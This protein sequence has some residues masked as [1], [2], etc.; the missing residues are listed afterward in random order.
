M[1]IIVTG[2]AGFIGS[3]ITDALL[4]AGH[5]V[6]IIDNLS[7]GRR[8][9][10]NPGAKFY[11]ADIRDKAVS[12]IFA[13]EKP[14]VVCHQAAQV[15]VRYSVAD[16]CADAD[17]N[18][19]GSI[20]L[21]ENCR[22]HGVGRMTFASS[23]GAIYGE[24]DVFPAPESHAFHPCSPYG[25]AKLSVEFYMDYYRQVFGLSYA[26]LRYSNVYGPRQ[27]P[28]G[29]AGVVAIFV[30]LMLEG[31]TPTVNGDGG[32]TRDYVYVKD[33]VAANV[34][35]IEGNAVGGFNI[36][37][38]IETSVNGLY[39]V[40]KEKTGY[41]GGNVHAPAK[42]GEQYRSV[43]DAAYAKASL[44]WSPKTSLGDGISETVAFFRTK[45]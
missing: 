33:V 38:G 25:T 1:K 13:A 15:S 18:I 28:H 20:N 27:D 32:Q 43:L 39:D 24:Q 16:P 36:G 31:K 30:G 42:A 14:D 26:A 9:N 37:T 44:G 45:N 19:V 23:G 34:A 21:L 6:A 10:L 12:D 11:H 41:A 3:H 5:D 35:A 7:T 4:T 29:E 8:E 2:G 17:I 40:I 22:I